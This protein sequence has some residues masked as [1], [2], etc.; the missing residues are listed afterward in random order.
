[1]AHHEHKE[2]WLVEE[3]LKN[4]EE[5]E[6]TLREAEERFE[7]LK[8]EFLKELGAGDPYQRKPFEK[9][10]KLIESL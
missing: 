10:I 7:K 4:E 5:L 1:M 8:R 3:A 6:R 2:T 9:V